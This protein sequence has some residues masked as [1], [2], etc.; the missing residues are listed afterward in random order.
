[1]RGRRSTSHSS[2]R[3]R[4]PP[5]TTDLLPVQLGK[6]H[7]AIPRVAFRAIHGVEKLVHV[8][9]R[10]DATARRRIFV[11]PRLADVV[12]P[13]LGGSIHG[14]A[15]VVADLANDLADSPQRIRRV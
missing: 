3:T 1:M 7:G 13:R 10:L 5:R 2:P 11:G 15:T 9:R 4:A 12:V 6:R 14:V 8:V